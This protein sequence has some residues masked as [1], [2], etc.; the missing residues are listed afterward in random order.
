M[1]SV[2][3]WSNKAYYHHTLILSQTILPRIKYSK[4]EHIYSETG[5]IFHLEIYN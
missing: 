2:V 1:D 4:Y 3:L 5:L